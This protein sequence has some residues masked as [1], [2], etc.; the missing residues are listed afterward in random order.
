MNE[1]KNECI[2]SYPSFT[3]L[4]ASMFQYSAPDH[5]R[6]Y[7]IRFNSVKGTFTFAQRP[8][9]L[10]TSFSSFPHVYSAQVCI[11]AGLQA[12]NNVLRIGES[13]EGTWF[14]SF[15]KN[16]IIGKL[17]LGRNGRAKC[18]LAIRSATR[19]KTRFK[20]IYENRLGGPKF[21]TLHSRDVSTRNRFLWWPKIENFEV[22]A[23]K[24][25]ITPQPEHCSEKK[26]FWT[27]EIISLNVI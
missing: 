16:Y 21:G 24:T 1:W 3:T 9:A 13:S 2:Q 26:L 20:V 5:I 18:H 19:L 8:A 15:A 25:A 17:S 11:D 12:V 23:G 27:Q 6:K 4:L 22:R 7:Q 14:W 10:A